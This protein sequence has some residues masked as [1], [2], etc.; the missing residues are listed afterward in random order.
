M[1]VHQSRIDELRRKRNELFSQIATGFS[2]AD[3]HI[4][5]INPDGLARITFA[6][7]PTVTVAPQRDCAE[8]LIN[9]LLKARAIAA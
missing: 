7:C 6:L 4:G 3:L 1:D 2:A 5:D 8:R 9:E